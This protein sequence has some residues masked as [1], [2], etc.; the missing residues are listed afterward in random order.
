MRKQA[1]VTMFMI[2]GLIILLGGLITYAAFTETLIFKPPEEQITTELD[3]Q[4]RPFENVVRECQERILEEGARILLSRGGYINNPALISVIPPHGNAVELTEGLLIPYWH[5]IEDGLYKTQRPQL[6]SNNA[7]SINT[8]LEEYV[9]ERIAACVPWDNFVEYDIDYSQPTSKITFTSLDT[10]IQTDWSVRVQANAGTKSYQHFTATVNAP[11]KHLYDVVEEQIRYLR[12]ASLPERNTLELLSVYAAGNTDIPPISGRMEFTRGFRIWQLDAA[13]PHLQQVTSLANSFIQVEGSRDAEI[14]ISSEPFI[15]NLQLDSLLVSEHN[16][17][18][19]RVTFYTPPTGLYYAV[20]GNPAVAVP[21][22]MPRPPVIG[23]LVPMMI[24]FAF[25]Q[26]ITYPLLIA[27]S[28]DGYEL[29]A[30]YQVN[31][32]N[33]EAQR[34]STEQAVY[35]ENP[36]IDAGGSNVD[37]RIQTQTGAS[38]Q[39]PAT[40]LYTCQTLTCVVGETRSATTTQLPACALG[41]LE[42]VTTEGFSDPIT[43]TSQAGQESDIILTVYEEREVTLRAEARNIVKQLVYEQGMPV[44]FEFVLSETI[45][46]VQADIILIRQNSNYVVAGRTGETISIVP[47]TYDILLIE[48]TDFEPPYI[49]PGKEFSTGLFSS[50]TIP[51]MPIPT[52]PTAYLE[53]KGVTIG[54]ASGDELVITAASIPMQRVGGVLRP[55]GIDDVFDL[56]ILEVLFSHVEENPVRFR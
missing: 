40:I 11:I 50:E 30:A 47:G 21:T 34:A 56:E 52:L 46:P 14:L 29:Q 39:E 35:S 55:I 48:V 27:A 37:V 54:V 31:I 19:T 44:G 16:L 7:L 24:D 15:E 53:Q 32:R 20:D 41:T 12:A 22:I 26:D 6:Q 10:T 13:K 28:K 5:Y 9:D 49:I 38:L 18:E 23:F 42:A 25:Q 36:C 43:Y 51:A 45:S 4:L 1:Q 3:T 17:E 2:L 8:Q 33:N